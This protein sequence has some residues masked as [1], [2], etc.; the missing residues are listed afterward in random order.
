M[1]GSGESCA[2]DSSPHGARMSR[3]GRR[4][5]VGLTGNQAAERVAS[6]AARSSS[7]SH[8][9]RKS[10]LGRTACRR[11]TSDIVVPGSPVSATIA[12]FCS[13]DQDRRVL[14]ITMLGGLVL[15]PD[16]VPIHSLS[17]P[18]LS[19]SIR[20]PAR[21]PSPSANLAARLIGSLMTAGTDARAVSAAGE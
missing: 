12:R 13:R 2:C 6:G 20:G 19:G 16:I 1:C 8:R 11:A 17:A 3:G 9:H 5:A 14:A 7:M 15:A 18:F 21:R 10:R 4:H